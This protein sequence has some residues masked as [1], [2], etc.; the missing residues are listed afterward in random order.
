VLLVEDNDVNQEVA[1]AMLESGGC[2]VHAVADGYAALER[3]ATDRYDVV[4]MDCQMPGL[5]GFELTRRI[6]EREGVPEA[7]FPS[8]GAAGAGSPARRTLIVALTANAMR[9]DRERCLAA[10]MDDY[11]IKPFTERQLLAV[12]HR[13]LRARGPRGSPDGDDRAG[14]SVASI[15]E[16]ARPMPASPIDQEALDAIRALGRR[17]GSDVLGRVVRLYLTSSVELVQALSAAAARRDGPALRD[18]AHTLKSSSASVGAGGLAALCADLEALG[19]AERVEE[20]C[21]R[22]PELVAEYEGV[23]EALARALDPEAV[24]RG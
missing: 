21:R 15:A 24:R 2:T 9:G 23:R 1:A 4:L 5:D 8:G 17:A 11:L 19:R 12:L 18:L 13:R 3:L 10:G 22:L 6:R 14:A 20:A 16:T 7:D